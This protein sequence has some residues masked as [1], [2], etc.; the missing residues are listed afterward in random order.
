MINI[1]ILGK[2]YKDSEGEAKIFKSNWIHKGFSTKEDKAR[3]SLNIV[4]HL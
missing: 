3:T 4:L 1:E 2:F